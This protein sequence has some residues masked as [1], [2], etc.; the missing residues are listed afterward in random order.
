MR[1]VSRCA[2]FGF[3]SLTGRRVPRHLRSRQVMPSLPPFL[4]SRSNSY[5]SYGW[6]KRTGCDPNGGSTRTHLLCADSITLRAS[7]A[8]C[9][10]CCELCTAF[11]SF[12]CVVV[13]WRQ[14]RSG[15]QDGLSSSPRMASLEQEAAMWQR[16]LPLSRT[17]T[18]THTQPHT[19][20]HESTPCWPARTPHLHRAELRARGLEL[21][22]GGGGLPP[23]SL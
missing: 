1:L 23:H 22:A 2:W 13:G 20:T 5:N 11:A 14:V 18:H 15:G 21:R 6:P 16:G 10:A 7:A 8:C 19:L 3:L 9:A 12:A 4:C 17:C